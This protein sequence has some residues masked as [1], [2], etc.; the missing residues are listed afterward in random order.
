MRESRPSL[1]RLTP[2]RGRGLPPVAVAIAA[3]AII[4]LSVGFAFG[5]RNL[6]KVGPSASP[7]PAFAGASIS[8][9]LR[10]A[11]LNVVG[12]GWA[13]C[14][15]E[16]VVTCQPELAIPNI[17]LP[18]FQ[19][20]PVSV[21]ANDWGVFTAVTV[22]PGHYIL[23]GPMFA[24]GPQVA[25]A[26]VAPNGTGTVIGQ[27]DQTVQDEVI[28]VDLGTLATGRYVG[29]VRGYGLQAGASDGLINAT[30]IGWAV[31]LIVGR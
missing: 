13:V 22:P 15:I 11:Y 21:S 20:L 17:E 27:A 31:G 4:A 8:T 28:Y 19:E 25:F 6:A 10:T 5:S 18:D 14:S 23:A 26:T 16:G 30:V 24:V 29:V 3:V 9:E 1:E 2:R 7:P 12:G